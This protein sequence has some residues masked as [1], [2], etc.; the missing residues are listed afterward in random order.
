MGIFPNKNH[1]FFGVTP[2]AMETPISMKTGMLENHNE[3]LY[4]LWKIITSLDVTQYIII[5]CHIII[6]II[7]SWVITI[8]LFIDNN[9]R[10]SSQLF[11]ITAAAFSFTYHDNI[12]NS[13]Q[14]H[15]IYN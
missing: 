3:S 9:Y 14:S 10:P 2:M 4:N 11:S 15:H 1:L 6:N 13:L 7:D 12:I 5:Y 8:E